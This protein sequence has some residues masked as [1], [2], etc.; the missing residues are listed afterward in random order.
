M[1]TRVN[2]FAQITSE[3]V[4]KGE[5]IAEARN[6]GT[7]HPKSPG[8]G[9]QRRAVRPAAGRAALL[10]PP[11]GAKGPARPHPP[12]SFILN[13]GL[14]HPRAPAQA[15]GALRGPRGHVG[16]QP[17]P[18]VPALPR[19]PRVLGLRPGVVR[20]A[21][22]ARAQDLS[23]ATPRPHHRPGRR[24]GLPYPP[25]SPRCPPPGCPPRPEVSPEPPPQHRLPSPARSDPL[26]S[27]S[28]LP[29]RAAGRRKRETEPPEPPSGKSRVESRRPDWAVTLIILRGSP[30]ILSDPEFGLW[31]SLRLRSPHARVEV[32]G[33]TSGGR[34]RAAAAVATE[35]PREM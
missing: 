8:T 1:P 10:E 14:L 35:A 12:G 6:G 32:P 30:A 16:P 5:E 27:A 33:S 25:G 17:P 28:G 23:P 9:S 19:Y 13:P 2:H 18:R 24:P 21:A 4:F 11:P 34:Y 15:G 31:S 22:E 3:N 29:G 20:D 26:R 7:R